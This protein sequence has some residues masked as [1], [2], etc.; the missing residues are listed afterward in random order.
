MHDLR[1]L[2]LVLY[3]MANGHIVRSYVLGVKLR[4]YS[5]K[6][7]AK[8]GLCLSFVFILPVSIAEFLLL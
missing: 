2:C 8:I 5:Q 4:Y 6:F 7:S 3:P 1:T